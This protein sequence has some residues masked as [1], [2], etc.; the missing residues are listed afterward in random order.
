MIGSLSNFTVQPE[1]D[2]S[3]DASDSSKACSIFNCG[4]PS[5]SKHLP[6]K[7]FFLPF[8][9][10]VSSPCFKAK[11][12]IAWT[13]SLIVIPGC[14]LPLNLTKTLSGISNGITPNVAANATIP[15]PAGKLIPIGNRV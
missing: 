10:K 3:A 12:G 13:K 1:A 6:E 7:I 15:D 5:I 11:Y 2:R 8:L 14:K 9:S 4:S